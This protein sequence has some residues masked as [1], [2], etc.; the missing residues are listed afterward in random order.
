MVS[1][2]AIYVATSSG[3]IR[4]RDGGVTW[5]ATSLAARVTALALDPNNPQ[6]IYA[7]AAGIYV[8]R[9]RRKHLDHCAWRA[10]ECASP[11]GAAVHR[12][13]RLRGRHSGPKPFR[14][15]MD[16]RR[17]DDALL[18][19]CRRQLLGLRQ[20]HR[21]GWAG[22]RLRDRLHLFERLP[23]HLQRAQPKTS[24][25]YTPFAARSVPTEARWPTQPTWVVR[26][27]TRPSPSPWIRAG[28]RT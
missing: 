28:A 1:P 9:G 13:H 6:T 3:T 10:P 12:V 17:Q 7:A 26:R 16:P 5:T 18:H 20:S 25:V 14:Y 22:Q 4:S 11:G 15:E 23:G 24:A 8:E 2:T 21:G 27:R 19:L